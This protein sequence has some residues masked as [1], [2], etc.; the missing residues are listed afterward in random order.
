MSD[1][2]LLAD[3]SSYG[4]GIVSDGVLIGGRGTTLAGLALQ[5]RTSSAL[6][7]RAFLDRSGGFSVGISAGSPQIENGVLAAS[8][9][10][11]TDMRMYADGSQTGLQ[12]GDRG[13]LTTGSTQPVL[14]FAFNANGSAVAFSGARLR[15]YSIGYGLSGSGVSSFTTAIQR[16][17]T[18]LS[19]T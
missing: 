14:V 16:F 6:I 1:V 2:H 13:T 9:V 5:A 15:C 7:N 11:A 17:N 3:G 8:S 4:L 18:A 10:S 12:T 19:R